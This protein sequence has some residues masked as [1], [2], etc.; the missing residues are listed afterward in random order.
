[1]T[2]L[3]RRLP[4]RRAEPPRPARR[5]RPRTVR[6]AGLTLALTA[7]LGLAACTT[8]AATDGQAVTTFDAASADDLPTTP[9]GAA[10]TWVV[11]VLG[12]ATPP[13]AADI[14]EHFAASYLATT[15]VATTQQALAEA[16]SGGPY[17]MVGFEDGGDV[18][19][20]SID[21]AAGP[22][23]AI[24]IEVDTQGDLTAFSLTQ[25]RTIPTIASVTDL[26]K[27]L[28]G[29]ST[30]TA[31]LLARID[32]SGAGCQAPVIASNADT[33]MPVGRLADL[34]VLGAVAS[35]IDN[36][37]L[38][39]EEPL[40][41][42]QSLVA[43]G[44]G[45]L[46]D[47]SVGATVSVSE[48]AIRMIRESDATASTMLVNAVGEGTV[49]D[50][51]STMG[52]SDPTSLNPL[53]TPRALA[54]IAWSRTG[55]REAWSAAADAGDASAT[56]AHRTALVNALG[57]G[58]PDVDTAAMGDIVWPDGLS[59]FATA[60]DV[61]QAQT[62]L[63]D[64]EADGAAAAPVTS[65]A[66]VAQGGARIDD[67]V[68]TG[69]TYVG[70]IAPGQTGMAWTFTD[71]E[72][73]RWSLVILQAGDD[74]LSYPSFAWL[75]GVA[76]QLIGLVPGLLGLSTPTPTAGSGTAAPASPTVG[77]PARATASPT[78][79]E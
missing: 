4:A 65:A 53:L 17:E 24:G 32:G 6:A 63:A 20:L 70:A 3:R 2:H 71:T 77:E 30:D 16:R 11:S 55:M 79:E 25:V 76:E 61:C 49:R 5:R 23:V 58:N 66:L 56:L 52:L 73:A 15:P 7:A 27:A 31:Y 51:A 39:G 12:A 33:T 60:E 22:R 9:A 36:G 10:A 21:S 46:S 1:M 26:D 18:L 54:Q 35:A 48:A 13:T 42:T 78:P 44:P 14:E 43:P 74:P 40:T 45:R 8:P 69:A 64:L 62:A 47:D 67:A 37:D 57:R 75:S 41:L 72:G 38:D 50:A 68:W 19:L 59:W 28:E 34:Y 29:T